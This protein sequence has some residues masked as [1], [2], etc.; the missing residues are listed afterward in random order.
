MNVNFKISAISFQEIRECLS[1][2]SEIGAELAKKY[3]D[4]VVN[5][6][7]EVK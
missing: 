4:I 7:V 1:T 2:I 3:P 5:V 6:E